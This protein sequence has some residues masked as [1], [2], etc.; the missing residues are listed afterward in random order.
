MTDRIEELKAKHEK[1]LTEEIKVEEMRAAVLAALDLPESAWPIG[2]RHTYKADCH[3][4]LEADTLSDAMVLAEKMNPLAIARVKGSCLA[5][6]PL[7]AAPDDDETTDEIENIGPWV[8]VIDGLRQHSDEKTLKFYVCAASY[9]VEVKVKVKSDPD[10]YRDYEIT[11]NNHGEAIKH[12]N[13]L[14]NKSG[15]FTKYNRFWSSDDQPGRFV[16]Y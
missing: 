7:D 15:H 16:L 6:M 13:N 10:T 8:Y 12:R 9:T 1:E 11:F 4:D 3:I 5:F 14:V 2:A